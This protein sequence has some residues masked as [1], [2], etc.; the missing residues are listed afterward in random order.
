MNGGAVSC[1]N[2][3]GAARVLNPQMQPDY[4]QIAAAHVQ[5]DTIS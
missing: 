4:A 1:G 3:E 2:E 5:N